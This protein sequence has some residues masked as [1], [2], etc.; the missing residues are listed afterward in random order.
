MN[1]SRVFQLF[2]ILV[3]GCLFIPLFFYGGF[4][5][6]F[7]AAQVLSFYVLVQCAFPF[8]LS[9][10]VTR[11]ELRPTWKN[12]V[13]LSFFLYIVAMTISAAFGVDPWNSF[14]G[15]GNRL[16]G[17]ILWMHLFVFYQYLLVL[18]QST[19]QTRKQTI[20]IFLSIAGICGLIG[21]LQIL[22][23]APSADTE[24]YG[25][26]S[27]STIGNPI[28]FAA[29]L[30]I[31]FFLSI[32]MAM[33]EKNV[34]WKRAFI[35]IT[36]VTGLGIASSQTRGA[37]IGLMI[38]G[39]VW[40]ISEGV[41]R[42]S[43]K[44]SRKNGTILA[45][46]VLITIGSFLAVRFNSAP[47]SDAYRFTH[48]SDVN[49][50]SRLVYWQLALKGW[51]DVP[52]LGVGY[53]NFF[54][55]GD[56]YYS[57]ALYSEGGTWP[58]KPHNQL[59]EVLVTGGAVTILTYLLFFF[60]LTREIVRR[61][62]NAREISSAI[63]LATLAA[64]F[65]QNLFS[66]DT[67]VPMISFVVFVGYV[68]SQSPAQKMVSKNN[69]LSKFS[70][71]VW[72]TAVIPIVIFFSW[73]VPTAKLFFNT[74][75]AEQSQN[76]EDGFAALE[77]IKRQSF[78]YD[79]SLL[80]QS[81]NTILNHELGSAQHETDLSR[82]IGASAVETAKQAVALH[83][84]RANDWY[85]YS[86]ILFLQATAKQTP[87][88]DAAI[89]IANHTIELAPARI[90]AL[91]SLANMYDL[92]GDSAKAMELAQKAVAVAPLNA[93]ALWTLSLLY[94]KADKR[95]EAAPLA[96]RSIQQKVSLNKADA[97]N[98]LINYYVDKKD[99]AAVVTLYE[100]SVLI[101]PTNSELLPKLA[102]A[103]AMNH[104]NDKAI[105]T[106]EKYKTA[107]PAAAAGVDAFIQT[108]R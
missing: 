74:L 29:T 70:S 68:T 76:R 48:F 11:P 41:S 84:H 57:T 10:I 90:E 95:D 12:P 72:I 14:F 8:F 82:R 102:A 19:E 32:G 22:H 103:Y 50:S 20:R 94:V 23:L 51:K 47:D 105:A 77:A 40:L 36:I 52:L 15:N 13:T 63:L 98:W 66:F 67:I 75:I 30:L 26:R 25:T 60:F 33:K 81:Y 73:I 4:R 65:I 24:L 97:L 59:L 17:V 87:V 62:K 9:L 46:G 42:R 16:D 61:E 7:Q 78:I 2:T 56:K 85:N 96:L 18:F 6:P 1:R 5:Q 92:N 53:Q 93:E 38:G 80:A 45:L 107:N 104:Q 54:V 71:V 106:A 69:L 55:I 44:L 58:D 99:T 100:K 28:F 27:S 83:P 31:P 64:F 37:F 39:F 49:V 89:A 101:E 108:L 3:S 86:I 34:N 91:V 88:S 35:A 21:I 79:I 43:I